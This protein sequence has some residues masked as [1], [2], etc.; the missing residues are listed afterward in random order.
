[1]CVHFLDVADIF[2]ADYS[3]LVMLNGGCEY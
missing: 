2:H 1:L 3:M